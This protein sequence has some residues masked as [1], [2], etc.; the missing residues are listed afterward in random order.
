MVVGGVNTTLTPVDPTTIATFDKEFPIVDPEDYKKAM[1]SFT[2]PPGLSTNNSENKTV[3]YQFNG[4]IQIDNV[5]DL[6]SFLLE[7]TQVATGA[8]QITKNE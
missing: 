3:V 2:T 5:A 1:S 4:G 7:I 6:P 8:H